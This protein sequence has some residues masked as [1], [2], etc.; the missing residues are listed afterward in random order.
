[1]FNYENAFSNGSSEVKFSLLVLVMIFA[2]VTKLLRK[3]S[4]RF[5]SW[6]SGGRK[7]QE[8]H[9][10]DDSCQPEYL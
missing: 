9:I 5:S 8:C 3:G 4:Q 1:M 2:I 6:V 7:L 10:H